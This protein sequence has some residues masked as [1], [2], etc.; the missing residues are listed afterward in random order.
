MINA[1]LLNLTKLCLDT[2]DDILATEKAMAKL[3]DKTDTESM[4]ELA[5]LV[6]RYEVL[7]IT[8]QAMK[9]IMLNVFEAAKEQGLLSPEQDARIQAIKAGTEDF[10]PIKVTSTVKS[11]KDVN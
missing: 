1:L 6:G 2:A 8:A 5:I 4:L 9:V 3:K 7:L 10:E 11:P